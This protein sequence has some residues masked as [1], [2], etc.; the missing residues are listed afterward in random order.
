[1]TNKLRVPVT[2]AQ[3]DSCRKAN[4]EVLTNAIRDSGGG[5]P[6]T[7]GTIGRIMATLDALDRMEPSGA[8]LPTNDELA[9]ADKRLWEARLKGETIT[10]GDNGEVDVGATEKGERVTVRKKVLDR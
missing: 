6:P 9:L 7:D 3:L 1:M 2:Q 10:M 4:M 8:V 5:N